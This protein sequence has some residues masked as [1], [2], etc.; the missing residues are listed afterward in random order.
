MTLSTVPVA[1]P[2]C[3]ALRAC[4]WHWHHWLRDRQSDEARSAVLRTHFALALESTAAYSGM[5]I[6]FM[7]CTKLVAPESRL[8]PSPAVLDVLIMNGYLQVPVHT[9][10]NVEG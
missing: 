6:I 3:L 1:E 4:H 7:K 2:T 8:T 9:Q 10:R 5:A